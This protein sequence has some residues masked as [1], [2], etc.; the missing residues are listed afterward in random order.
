MNLTG[1]ILS[2]NKIRDI[3]LLSK[4][5]NL[6]VLK[7]DRNQITDIKPLTEMTNL[8]ELSLIQNPVENMLS[9]SVLLEKAPNIQH[10]VWHL[11]YSVEKI[12]GPWLWMI[13]PTGTGQGGAN[14]IDVDSLATV[15]KGIV[16]ENTVA[17]KGVKEGD[18]VGENVWRQA[19]ISG[20]S[21]NN[22]NEL[23]K[24]IGFKTGSD[25]IIA[26]RD[27]YVKDH[28][29]YALITLKSAIDQPDVRMFVGSDD[30]IKVWLNGKVVYKN[31]INRGAENFQNSFKVDLKAGDNLL[32]V[33]VGQSGSKWSMFVGI[34]ADINT[35]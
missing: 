35:K 31:A 24:K 22:L 20:T 6:R 15:S 11:I 34:D 5:K 18:V 23:V 19:K 16:T 30:A 33:K 21:D 29:A 9:L 12:T 8:R 1:L 10:D 3:S 26:A 27:V 17:V 2:K 13:A 28:S 4:L 32:L 25:P 14:S 7:I